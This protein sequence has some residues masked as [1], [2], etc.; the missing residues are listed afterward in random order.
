M[1]F[2]STTN[3]PQ[4]VESVDPAKLWAQT[5]Q[6][7]KP[8]KA[9]TTRTFYNTPASAVTTSANEKRE[10]VRKAVGS[11]VKDLKAYEGLKDVAIDASADPHAADFTSSPFNPNLTEPSRRNSSSALCKSKEWERGN[12]YAQAQNLARTLM[13]LPANL[14][15]PT[16]FTERVK[17]EFEGVPN[18]EIFVRDEAPSSPSSSSFSRISRTFSFVTHGTSEPAKFLEIHYKGA[19]NKDEQPLA[20][21]GKGI[22]FDSG[23]ISLKPGAGMKLMRGDMGGAATVV[24]SALA[25]AKLQLPINLVVSTPLTENMPGPSATKPG[26]IIYAMNGKSIEVDNT[27]AEGR[28]VL[29]DAIYYTATE[30]KP[31]TLIDVATLTGAMVI[32]LGEVYSGVF[33]T[34]DELWQQ[35]HQAGEV[36]HDRFW[37][38]PLDDEFGPQIHSSNADLQNTGGRPAGSIT[39]ALFLKPFAE[40]CEGKDGQEPTLKWAHIDIAGSM[41]ATRPSPYQEKGM[42]GRPVRALVEYVRRLTNA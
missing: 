34:S 15:T 41:E 8:P 22:T 16:A 24:S 13:E 11:A 4:L 42:T 23:G 26:D 6:G 40:G 36:E 19:A 2:L 29:S 7:E 31:H 18:V 27:D 38:M 14:M 21:V 35:L 28:L 37:R 10:I 1:S 33:S 20:F 5:P 17:K 30:Y 39:A 12:V 3:I 25:I 32:A 9:G